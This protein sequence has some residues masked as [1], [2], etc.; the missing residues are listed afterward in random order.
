MPL[1]ACVA[2]LYTESVEDV[3]KLE[4]FLPRGGCP[5]YNDPSER[6]PMLRA[7]KAASIT[8]L[9]V[10]SLVLAA[11]SCGK[12]STAPTF[13]PPLP[14]AEEPDPDE[15][16]AYVPDGGANPDES[17]PSSGTSQTNDETDD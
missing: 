15:E 2:D 8:L 5:V 17:N 6:I 13:S 14:P 7:S 11:A 4:R 9:C 12:S 3:D 16:S 10:S 1:R